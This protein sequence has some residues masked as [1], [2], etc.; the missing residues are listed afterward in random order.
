MRR[1]QNI[2]LPHLPEYTPFQQLYA[3]LPEITP[4]SENTPPFFDNY[5]SPSL[6]EYIPP[7]LS[8]TICDILRIY[9]SV[10]QYATFSRHYMLL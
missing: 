6:S 7:H 4:P 3:T 8:T 9:P 5:M 1:S 2:F 10:T